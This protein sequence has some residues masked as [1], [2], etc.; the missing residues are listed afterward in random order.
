MANSENFPHEPETIGSESRIYRQK[1]VDAVV[2]QARAEVLAEVLAACKKRLEEYEAIADEWASLSR[3]EAIREVRR[4]L[5]TMQPA[6]SALE[7]LLRESELQGI[8][9]VH[10]FETTHTRCR[11]CKRIAELE[12][13]RAIEGKG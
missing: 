4:S 3:S 12:K 5:D 2:K 1:D 10:R 7:A 8:L 13:A 11:A 6:A 9:L